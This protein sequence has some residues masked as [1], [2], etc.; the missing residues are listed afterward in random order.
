VQLSLDVI[1][2]QLAAA[3]S[4]AETP[5][6]FAVDPDDRDIMVG[7]FALEFRPKFFSDRLAVVRG[8]DL[9]IFA[10]ISLQNGQL[11]ARAGSERGFIGAP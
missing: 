1:V 3:A 2:I 10:Y 5:N 6:L 8:K 7:A 11:L 4:N 9:R